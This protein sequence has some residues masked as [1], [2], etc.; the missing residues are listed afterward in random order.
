MRPDPSLKRSAN[1]SAAF[2]CLFWSEKKVSYQPLRVIYGVKSYDRSRP[3]GEVDRAP[4]QPFD[5]GKSRH[6]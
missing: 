1:V 3:M 4:K 2:E 6:R 5:S